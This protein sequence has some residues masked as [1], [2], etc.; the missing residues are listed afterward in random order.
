MRPRG[1]RRQQADGALL[2]GCLEA[3][4]IKRKLWDREWVPESDFRAFAADQREIA[5]VLD[6]I[7]RMDGIVVHLRNTKRGR[8]FLLERAGI[9][10]MSESASNS[11]VRDD[12]MERNK[13]VNRRVRPVDDLNVLGSLRLTDPARPPVLVSRGG[14]TMG[15]PRSKDDVDADAIRCAVES[16]GAQVDHI[17]RV[18][19]VGP[20]FRRYR[21]FLA[22]GE[23]YRHLQRRSEDLSRELGSEILVAQVSGERWVAIDVARQDRQV[24]PLSSIMERFPSVDDPAAIWLPVGVGPDGQPVFLD[25][26][27]V[28]HILVAGGTGGGKSVWLRSVL[29]SLV[30]KYPSRALEILLI[31]GKAIDFGAFT[32]VP[33]LRGGRIVTEAE[34]AVAL[35]KELAGP[36]LRRRTQLLQDTRCSSFR[37]LRLRKPGVDAGYLVVVIDEFADL[38]MTLDKPQRAEFEREIVRLGQ[39]ARAAGIFLILSTQRPTVE[40]VT[41]A[42]K[43]NLATRVSF[44]LPSRVDSQV[45][46]D[47]PGAEDLLG[48]GDLLLLHEGRLQRLQGCFSSIDDVSQLIAGRLTVAAEEEHEVTKC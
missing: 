40:F 11:E 46:L 14:A 42:I 26:T 13:A 37:E 39:R 22:P 10:K 9:Q 4:G 44:R 33:H 47:G 7:A 16:I 38:A 19:I 18:P 43:T 21:V 34:E 6:Q 17:E 3:L 36:E 2:Q 41:G 35:L 1:R 31:D 20:T 29:L 15:T 24:V 27:L 12:G 23:R 32:S 8:F 45:I 48:A 28:P 5:R 25:L 30:L